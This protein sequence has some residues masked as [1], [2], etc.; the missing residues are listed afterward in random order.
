MLG[1]LL[2]QGT[3][4]QAENLSGLALVVVAVREHGLDQGSLDLLENDVVKAARGVAVQLFKVTLDRQAHLFAEKTGIFG[5][6]R[7]VRLA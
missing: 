3:A 6:R 1:H 4:A 2:A 5:Q 7:R